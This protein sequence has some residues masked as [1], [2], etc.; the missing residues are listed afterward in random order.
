M[1][2]NKNFW[3]MLVCDVVLLSL[4]YLSAYLF[5][6]ER[7]IDAQSKLLIKETIVPLLVC[8]TASFFFF[9]L[10]RGMWRYTSVMDLINIIKASLSGSLLFVL[11][12]SM[13]YHFNGISRAIILTDLVFT[14]VAIG[15]LRLVI[16][17]YYQKAPGFMD[18][19]V[20]WRRCKNDGKKALI[21]GLV[22]L[23]NSFSESCRAVPNCHLKPSDSL[24]RDRSTRA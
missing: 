14:I 13:V 3:V 17:L 1:F 2:W 6:F 9:D 21:I 24:M 20:F 18:E 10:Y 23:P 15:G 4:C 7:L 8:K 12:L 22:R 16:R 5:R 11:Y 19:I